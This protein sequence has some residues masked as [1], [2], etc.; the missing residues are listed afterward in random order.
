MEKRTMAKKKRA[1]TKSGIVTEEPNIRCYHCNTMGYAKAQSGDKTR[2]HEG[3]KPYPN[4]NVRRKC[5]SCGKN[6][7]TR[8][9]VLVTGS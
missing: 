2:V 9:P 8:R 5:W 3:F 1:Y 4:G 7:I 6:F